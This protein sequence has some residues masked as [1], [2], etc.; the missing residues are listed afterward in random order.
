LLDQIPE[1]AGY[2]GLLSAE[3]PESAARVGVAVARCDRARAIASVGRAPGGDDGSGQVV[4]LIYE[5]PDRFDQ[6]SYTM[7]AERR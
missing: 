5:M 6:S 3:R 1:H 7:S 4:R 2:T